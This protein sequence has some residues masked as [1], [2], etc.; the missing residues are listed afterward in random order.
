MMHRAADILA[1]LVWPKP[2]PK[3]LDTIKARA[4]VSL[5][6]IVGMSGVLV[7]TLKVPSDPVELRMLNMNFALCAIS[8]LLLPLILKIFRNP[9][10]VGSLACWVGFLMVAVTAIERGGF[11]FGEP[12][13]F[14]S[15]TAASVFFSG[16]RMGLACTIASAA[17]MAWLFNH[18]DLGPALQLDDPI[19]NMASSALVSSLATLAFCT[20]I[21]VV[22]S[23]EMERQTAVLIAARDQAERANAAKSEF[24]ATMSHEIRTPMHGVLGMA[25]VLAERELSPDDLQMVRTVQTSGNALLTILNDVL[26]FSKIE[27][28]RMELDEAPFCLRSSVEDVAVLLAERAR[29][30][31]LLLFVDVDPALPS[32]VI[33]DFG[34]LRQVLTNLLGN[35]IKFTE[36]GHICIKVVGTAADGRASLRFTVSDTGIG[37][38]PNKLGTVF[39]SFRQA[40]DFTTRLYGGTGLGLSITKRLVAAMGGEIE[41]RSKLGQGSRFTFGLD[42]PIGQD[43]ATPQ[44]T[45]PDLAGRCVMV[46]L[47]NEAQRAAIAR[48]CAAWGMQPQEFPR[49][50][51][52]FCDTVCGGEGALYI[53]DGT[54]RIT[55][56]PR[57]GRMLLLGANRQENG[58]STRATRTN[59]HWIEKPL[60][61]TDL[62]NGIR[63]AL[64]LRR[65]QYQ[66]AQALPALDEVADASPWR[67]LV[68]DDNATNRLVIDRMMADH[69]YD[70]S[71]AYDGEEA[72][73]YA[74]LEAFDLILMDVS[75]PRLDGLGATKAIRAHERAEG[76]SP[77]PILALTAHIQ[78]A[79][80]ERF[81]AAGMNGCLTKPIRR[82]VLL[83]AVEGWITSPD[84]MARKFD[85]T[86]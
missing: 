67:I 24:L 65:T 18:G 28:G 43:E 35:A 16:W 70:L 56:H 75:M 63:D 77:A 82:L 34:R 49:I 52:A 69:Q 57:D 3:S 81:V 39:E 85:I 48:L 79:D 11:P 71:F 25:D 53:V 6:G 55:V 44:L 23:R 42:L 30:K 84:D 38:A 9:T 15:V 50:E 14:V 86:G 8:F 7:L 73:E 62:E 27:A 19:G 32:C 4:I 26:D 76:L 21:L 78:P 46:A 1:D 10:V 41:V 33:G 74:Q 37:I 13:I 12:V 68:A 58:P 66:S 47:Q 45:M 20:V 17:V 59:L 83:D 22:F 60:R 31:G 64:G 61:A 80:Q 29:D 36:D 54:E 5:A 40:E 2:F 51:D 72:V